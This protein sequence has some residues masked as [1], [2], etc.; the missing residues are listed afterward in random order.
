MKDQMRLGFLGGAVICGIIGIILLYSFIKALRLGN[1]S[2][3]WPMA[4][5][6]IISSGIVEDDEGYKPEISFSY[7]VHGEDFTSN[8]IQPLHLVSI[9]IDPKKTAER[10]AAKYFTGTTVNV[11]Y[12]PDDP[13]KAVLEPGIVKDTFFLLA[14]ALFFL[15]GGLVFGYV[16]IVVFETIPDIDE[17]LL[18]ALLSILNLF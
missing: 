4:E 9:P 16:S 17:A 1:A 2:K 3:T 5:G 11:Y 10:K 13:K 14:I 7:N 15:I 12:K 6:T 18:L 8:I